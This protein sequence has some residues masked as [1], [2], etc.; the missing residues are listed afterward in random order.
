MPFR[1]TDTSA[2]PARAKATTIEKGWPLSE[3]EILRYADDSTVFSS[4]C[5]IRL[6]CVNMPYKAFSDRHGVLFQLIIGACYQSKMSR[7]PP[8]AGKPLLGMPQPEAA[9]IDTAQIYAD[10][11]QLMATY[12]FDTVT[13]PATGYLGL[14]Y[15]MAR[16]KYHI[17][18]LHHRLGLPPPTNRD[19][20]PVVPGFEGLIYTTNTAPTRMAPP[21]QQPSTSAP[22]DLRLDPTSAV[23]ITDIMISQMVQ[24]MKEL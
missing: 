16:L 18:V 19:H 21:P 9:P 3:I 6:L 5:E 11:A 1:S 10:T 15:Q 12:S 20:L 8:I 17:A 13:M 7:Q 4:L 24:R 2:K 23:R 22:P 14:C